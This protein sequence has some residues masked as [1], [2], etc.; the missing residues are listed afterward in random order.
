MNTD[1]C[2]PTL[3]EAKVTV[4]GMQT[5]LHQWATDAPNRRFCDLYNLVYDPAFLMV[6]W[7]RIRKNR[8]AR[9][10][11][12]DHVRPSDI[13]RD[14]ISI[15]FQLRD[16]LKAGRFVPL[17]VRE[18]MI[19]KASGKLRRLGIPTARDRIVQASLKLVLEPIFEADFKPASY[20]FRP[21]RRPHDAIAE[22][23]MFASQG[24]SWVLEGD[25]TA[26]FDEI[27]HSALMDRVRHRIGDKRVLG[28]VKALLHSGILSEDGLTRETKSGTPQGG[29][30]SPLLANIALS[31]LD[32]HFAEVWERDMGTR[33]QRATRRK[34]KEATYR[35]IRYADDFVV[36]VHGTK[37]H[38]EA[39]RAEVAV[40]LSRVGLRLSP[41]KT[42]TVHIDE[43]FDFLGFR[44][45]R[46]TKRGSN[47]A[48]VYTWP[49]KKSLSSIKA[50]VKAITKQGTNNPLSSLLRQINGVLRGWTNYFRHGVSKDSFAYLHQY[51]W[52]RV[53]HWLRRKYRRANWKWLRRHY[54]ANAWMPEQDGEA[55][56]DCRSV[57]VTRYRY[58][59]A[60]IPSPW[61]GIEEKAS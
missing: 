42:M 21:R 5:K 47:K 48:Y 38:T 43:G 12:V 56:F 41:E 4:L 30:L 36:M 23:H 39:L 31:V 60:A 37:E 18:R 58:R 53:V 35:L 9:S 14:E 28:T 27:D 10:A 40:V 55:L 22:I 54:L 7:D 2:W 16:D 1:A 8:G 3:D 15:L 46:Q 29:I 26:C 61:V 19:P 33:S 45:Q 51:T 49:S 52:L 32:E 50:K 24:Y 17:P 20:G 11:G 13:P 57:Q 34:H 6:A 44:I 59:G 25:I